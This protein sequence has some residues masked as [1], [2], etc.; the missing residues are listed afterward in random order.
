MARSVFNLLVACKQ[1]EFPSSLL[2]GTG[3]GLLGKGA[4]GNEVAFKVDNE[5]VVWR[6]ATLNTKEV[7]SVSGACLSGPGETGIRGNVNSEND[8][9]RRVSAKE[10]GDDKCG[11]RKLGV[12]LGGACLIS[13]DLSGEAGDEGLDC[14]QS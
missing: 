8:M 11:R 10:C 12:V 4:A 6:G 13:V 7:S 5:R 9:I 3:K 2:R 1:F 14:S